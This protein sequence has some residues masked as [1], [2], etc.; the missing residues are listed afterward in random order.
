M[1][2]VRNFPNYFVD[3]I[4]NIIH[5]PGVTTCKLQQAGTSQY[6]NVQ[7]TWWYNTIGVV[8]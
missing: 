4:L 8:A 3:A 7:Y 2:P 1:C 6:F 5:L